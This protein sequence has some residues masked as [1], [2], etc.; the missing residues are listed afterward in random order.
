MNSLAAERSHS[1]M[2]YY[3]QIVDDLVTDVIVVSDDIADGAQFAHD[4]LGGEWVETFID[5]PNKNYAGIGYTYDA[6]NQNF[7][8]PQPYP[9]WILD[10]NDDWQPPVPQ[11]PAP[12][13]TTWDEQLQKWIVI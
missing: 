12:P 9:S 1:D 2:A 8:A 4:L 5:D 3:A 7:I 6:V 13:R 10:S 11:P